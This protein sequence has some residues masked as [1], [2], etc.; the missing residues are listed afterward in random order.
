LG[1]SGPI[2]TP[3]IIL[4]LGSIN[5]VVDYAILSCG[6]CHYLFGFVL[7]VA[8]K[9]IVSKTSYLHTFIKYIFKD[10]WVMAIKISN[11]SLGGISDNLPAGKGRYKI[12][13]LFFRQFVF[14]ELSYVMMIYINILVFW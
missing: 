3:F 12:T 8:S 14:I 5:C 2:R 1:F 6:F 4:S 13:V 11:I 7:I 9:F 10:N